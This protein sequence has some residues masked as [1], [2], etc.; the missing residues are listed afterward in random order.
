MRDFGFD[1]WAQKIRPTLNGHVHFHSFR[2]VA[3]IALRKYWFC[4]SSSHCLFFALRRKFSIQ[5][6]AFSLAGEGTPLLSVNPRNNPEIFCSVYNIRFK[7]R[8]SFFGFYFFTIGK[9]RRIIVSVML[10]S[11]CPFGV[12]ISF[13][14]FSETFIFWILC[15]TELLLYGN[16]YSFP[17]CLYFIPVTF[18]F[19]EG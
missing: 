15:I 5:L 16:F 13:H 3:L 14:G 18:I 7:L 4:F 8:N 17:V 10:Y 2:L 19:F 6:S 9:G 11:A 1:F 12:V